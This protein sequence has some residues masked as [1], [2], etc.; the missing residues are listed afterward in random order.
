LKLPVFDRGTNWQLRQL[1]GLGPYLS[2]CSFI[3]K[4]SQEV[5]DGVSVV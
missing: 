3:Q 4:N 1:S 2:L 5:M